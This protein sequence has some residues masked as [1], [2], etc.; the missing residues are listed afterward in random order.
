MLYTLMV[1]MALLVSGCG[2]LNFPS[3]NAPKPPDQVYNY[4]QDITTEPRVVQIDEQGRSVV[5]TAQHQSIEVG[6][7][8]KDKPL[9]WWQRLCNWLGNLGIFGIL[10]LLASLF[11][12]PAGTLGWIWKQYQ[13]YK[14]AMTQTVWAIEESKAVDN[15]Q[16]KAALASNHD[17]ET[18]KLVDDIRRSE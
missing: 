4:R 11:I 10:V 6:Y 9:S 14:K 8:R 7:E 5:F 2:F 12:A 1:L 17:N 13:K 15:N 16:V 18:K 3:L